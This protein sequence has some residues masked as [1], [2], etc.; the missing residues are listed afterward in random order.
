MSTGLAVWLPLYLPK[1]KAVDIPGA[2]TPGEITRAT[3]KE[4]GLVGAAH[5]SSARTAHNQTSQQGSPGNEPDGSAEIRGVRNNQVAGFGE[6]SG[7]RNRSCTGAFGVPLETPV[8]AEPDVAARA[9]RGLDHFGCGLAPKTRQ[10][11]I[12]LNDGKAECSPPGQP[13][14]PGPRPFFSGVRMAVA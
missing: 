1:V 11:V 3:R 4:A 7:S 14:M 9:H 8:A 10:A 5:D 12:C 2:P 13:A 6:R